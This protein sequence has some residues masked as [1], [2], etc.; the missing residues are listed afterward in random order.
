MNEG[1]SKCSGGGYIGCTACGAGPHQPCN[2]D[3]DTGRPKGYKKK[4][5]LTESITMPRWSFI[6]CV[7]IAIYVFN[8]HIFSRLFGM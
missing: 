1:M 6:V 8:M 5:W 4:N 7:I 2:W 3:Y